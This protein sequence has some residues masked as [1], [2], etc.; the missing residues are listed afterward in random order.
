MQQSVELL[1][2]EEAAELQPPPT[3]KL[4]RASLA[5]GAVSSGLKQSWYV[6]TSEIDQ[7]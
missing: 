7:A 6:G 2:E 1:E 5:G 3:A 4:L